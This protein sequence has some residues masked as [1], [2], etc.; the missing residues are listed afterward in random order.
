MVPSTTGLLQSECLW[1]SVLK[2]EAGGNWGGNTRFG[3]WGDC[4]SKQEAC[5]SLGGVGVRDVTFEGDSLSIC[6][7]LQGVGE[8]SSS[9]QNIVSGMLNL[10]QAFRT[11]AFS[12]TK[13]QGNVP[14]HLLAQHA[15]S[16]ENY[17]AWL[18]ECPSHIEHACAH[19]VFPFLNFEL[20]SS[21]LI[22]KKKKKHEFK[23]AQLW[24]NNY[25]I[26]IWGSCKAIKLKI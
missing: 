16:V 7:A 10:A 15:A 3:R 23:W 5:F 21:I 12:H 2:K 8:A 20:N 1:C 26:W 9:D 19:D 25:K 6:N 24:N 14:A 18:E 4:R 13:R 22:K 11:F 17:V